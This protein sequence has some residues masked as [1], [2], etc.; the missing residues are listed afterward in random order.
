[1]KLYLPVVTISQVLGEAMLTVVTSD[2]TPG[3]TPSQTSGRVLSLECVCFKLSCLSFNPSRWVL[4]SPS[5]GWH[6]P[7]QG[8]ITWQC[9]ETT[10]EVANIEY[11]SYKY[12]HNWHSHMYFL[13]TF[14]WVPS[15][16]T[17]RYGPSS[18]G[19][20]S[21]SAWNWDNS[22]RG[23]CRWTFARWIRLSI[24]HNVT[25]CTLQ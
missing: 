11:A 16:T 14:F 20:L 10:K 9:L 19:E 5:L 24:I 1:M 12:I 8:I 4:N 15:V 25:L 2:W 7:T 18:P 3:W 17:I 22:T 13:N 23:I 21:E 6:L